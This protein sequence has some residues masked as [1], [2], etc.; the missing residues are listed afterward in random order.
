[1]KH[2][3]DLSKYNIVTNFV[4]V[5][6]LVDGVIIRCGYRGSTTGQ[7]TPDPVFE[8]YIT[9]FSKLNTPVGTY[10]FTTA[11]NTSEAKEEADYVIDRLDQLKI[12]PSFPIFIDTE[13]SKNTTV[14]VAGQQT[15]I[16]NGRSDG[17][18]VSARTEI[19]KAFC[20]E[21]KS[22][23]YIPGIYASNSWFGSMLNMNS[24]PKYTL[25][26]ARYGKTPTVL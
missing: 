19:I 1:M 6:S 8:K 18:S 13:W 21:I 23:G 12:T 5:K 9:T 22:R 7:I 24:L 20:D 15:L 4:A 3:I 25:W 2:V 17:L 26:I 14:T 11:I 10:F 16:H